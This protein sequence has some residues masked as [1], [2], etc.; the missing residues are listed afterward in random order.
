M[1]PRF[2]SLLPILVDSLPHPATRNNPQALCRRI[3][4][5]RRRQRRQP[6]PNIVVCARWV[7]WPQTSKWSPRDPHAPIDG[8]PP[9]IQRACVA[10]RLDAWSNG[11]VFVSQ[12]PARVPR[13]KWGGGR[14][15][16]QWLEAG[17]S[18]APHRHSAQISGADLMRYVAL[19]RT[20]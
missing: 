12:N 17:E 20:P 7:V 10:A 11:R 16:A 15:R 18:I 4:L 6:A 9:F 19:S 5:I 3:K 1:A 2:N 8:P 13:Q 14:G